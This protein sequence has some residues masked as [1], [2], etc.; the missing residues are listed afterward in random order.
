MPL[1]QEVINE[2]GRQVQREVARHLDLAAEKLGLDKLAEGRRFHEF[3]HTHMGEMEQLSP[4]ASHEESE[5]FR[6]KILA[7]I[8]KQGSDFH[9]LIL[10]SAL[11]D[12]NVASLLRSELT[13]K[14]LET[15]KGRFNGLLDLFVDV[16]FEDPGFMDYVASIFNA[17]LGVIINIATL[18]IAYAIDS[19]WTCSFFAWPKQHE[20]CT[21]KYEGTLREDLNDE[22]ENNLEELAQGHELLTVK[23]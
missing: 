8:K 13:D 14:D 3:I 10:F 22:F 2:R 17:L 20:V 5:S 11:L 21:D 7:V 18:G 1:S 9:P 15:F 23:S 6:S 19:D 16:E 4:Q 12:M